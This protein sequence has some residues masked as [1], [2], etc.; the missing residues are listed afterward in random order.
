MFKK[1]KWVNLL[2]DDEQ[3]INAQHLRKFFLT[4]YERQEIWYKRFWDKE[5]APWTNNA[6]LRDNKFTNVYREL[7]RNSQWLINNVLLHCDEL[8]VNDT[9]WRIMLFRYFNQPALFDYASG[10]LQGTEIRSW[11][12]GVPSYA[13]YDEDEF[14]DHILQVRATGQRPYTSA[15][16]VNST[17]QSAPGMGADYIFGHIV[18]PNLHKNIPSIVKCIRNSKTPQVL[19]DLLKTLPNCS[20][21]LAHEFYQDFTYISIYT[22]HQF[23]RWTQ[24]D[25]TN[26]GPGAALGLRLVL[27]SLKTYKERVGGIRYLRDVA[28][29]EL[30]KIGDFKFIH[31][32]KKARCYKRS[33]PALSLH[34]IEMW[35]CEYGKYWKMQVGEGKQRSKYQHQQS[36]LQYNIGYDR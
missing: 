26:V 8:S 1:D 31:W 3:N 5:P 9:V 7:D 15:Y 34:Q 23:F 16:Y 20:D 32:D 27:P 35:L 36:E 25:F 13:E 12:N 24:N 18:I 21:F 14:A 17:N 33:S 2:P 30:L 6:I 4:M 19:I 11:Q 22:H 28:V 10:K 29:S